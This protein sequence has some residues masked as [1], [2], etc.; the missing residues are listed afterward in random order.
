[1]ALCWHY[2]AERLTCQLKFKKKKKK[3]DLFINVTDTHALSTNKAQ[4]ITDTL[5]EK[6][7]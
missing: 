4:L 3:L 5:A 7:F 1:M 6:G 2:N